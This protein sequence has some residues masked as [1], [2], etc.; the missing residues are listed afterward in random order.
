MVEE[1]GMAAQPPRPRHPPPTRL[2][3]IQ[4]RHRPPGPATIPARE[5]PR[6]LHTRVQRPPVL[7]QRP[8][9]PQPP[10]VA[11]RVGGSVLDLF[12]RLPIGRQEDRGAVDLAGHRR[13]EP[14]TLQPQP[15][16]NLP[17]LEERSLDLPLA[18]IVARHP[19]PALRGTHQ[20]PHTHVQAVSLFRFPSV[21]RPRAEVP[22]GPG[23]RGV[24]RTAGLLLPGE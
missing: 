8:Y 4:P 17:S 23:R 6:V 11:V 2:M 18:T 19:E 5:H 7:A 9:L 22:L 15:R 20:Q 13:D 10:L 12:P 24:P 3:L 14:P 1:E 21:R 16:R